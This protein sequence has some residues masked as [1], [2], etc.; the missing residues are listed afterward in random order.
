MAGTH[1]ARL[2]EWEA[3]PMNDPWSD[4]GPTSTV[5]TVVDADT[6]VATFTLNRPESR[7][8]ISKQLADELA[9][10]C[11]RLGQRNDVWAV[12]VTGAGELAFCAGADLKER[13]QL[14]GP[15]RA[16]HTRAIESAVES[17]AALPMPTIAA[18]R[19][20]ALAGGA[21]IAV[22]CDI[23]VAATDAVLGFPEV[24]VGI[25]P[26]AG[27]VLRLPGIIGQGAAR[28]LLFTGRNLA[29]DEALQIG[30]VDR[31]VES[32]S[33]LESATVLAQLIANNAPVAVRAVKRALR[34]SHGLS[35]PDARRAV[36]ALRAEL[37]GTED[38]EEGLRAFAE[39]RPPR[40]TGR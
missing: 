40:F 17:L 3:E 1:S 38:Y 7:N 11:E 36:N 18:I 24:R 4:P 5:A 20:F 12:I 30:L 13:R 19:G 23:R 27:G 34:Q 6:R 26:G 39:R 9:Q 32:E 21:E 35:L 22:A 8:A 10:A 15:E 28:D 16:A 29:A 25:F 37:D 31:I 33:V 14:S 2:E